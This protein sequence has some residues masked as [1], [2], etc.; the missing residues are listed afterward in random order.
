MTPWAAGYTDPAGTTHKP[1]DTADA[2]VSEAI[3]VHMVGGPPPMAGAQP[4][5]S[6]KI[7]HK[8][9]SRRTWAAGG[10]L[11]GLA[12]KARQARRRVPTATTR[13]A[14]TPRRIG[15][16]GRGPNPVGARTKPPTIVLGQRQEDRP[17]RQR[18]EALG[19]RQKGEK[20]HGLRATAEPG[21]RA[22]RQQHHPAHRLP[23]S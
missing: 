8:I 9:I 17:P 18:P 13:A 6:P 22:Q 14:T 23:G 5:H 11:N 10:E 7:S 21:G 15:A 3:L 19:H 4:V 1:K 16:T 2:A 12:A 20:L